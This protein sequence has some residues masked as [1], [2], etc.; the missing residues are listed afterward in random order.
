M[1]ASS[2]HSLSSQQESFERLPSVKKAKHE[3]RSLAENGLVSS[4][5]TEFLR[6]I[7][8]CSRELAEL[9]FKVEAQEEELLRMRTY[10]SHFG[11]SLGDDM[12]ARPG[13]YT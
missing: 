6:E 11:N 2:Q 9:R 4:L 3:Q 10:M 12:P 5:M 7:H 1:S 13:D 8:G